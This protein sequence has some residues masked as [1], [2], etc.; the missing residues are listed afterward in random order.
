MAI[1]LRKLL[2]DIKNPDEDIVVLALR[3][4]KRLQPA[5]VA[6]NPEIA[7]R[8]IVQLESLVQESSD[9]VTFFA[10]EC[11]EFVRE[12]AGDNVPLPAPEPAPAKSSAAQ[13][14]APPPKGG[15]A[16]KVE[17]AESVPAAPKGATREQALAALV[18]G[19]VDPR[20]VVAALVLLRKGMKTL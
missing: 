12:S 20:V 15:A 14:A 5:T 17:T 13:P 18:K 10:Q 1:D 4:V 19:V 6:N 2:Q 3:T 16:R 9:E 11:L 7:G 8:L